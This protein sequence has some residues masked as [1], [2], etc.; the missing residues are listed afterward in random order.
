[1]TLSGVRKGLRS[2]FILHGAVFIVSL[3]TFILKVAF[4]EVVPADCDFSGS[5]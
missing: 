5:Y 4:K 3:T 2:V 1:M